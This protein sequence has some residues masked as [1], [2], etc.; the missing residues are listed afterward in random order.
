MHLPWRFPLNIPSA[1]HKIIV[2]L[3][4][5]VATPERLARCLVLHPFVDT[6]DL[7]ASSCVDLKRQMAASGQSNHV[8]LRSLFLAGRLRDDAV[9]KWML[10]RSWVCNNSGSLAEF[11]LDAPA[12]KVPGS[13]EIT[14]MGKETRNAAAAVPLWPELREADKCWTQSL[15]KAEDYLSAVDVT[16]DKINGASEFVAKNVVNVIYD[17]DA[18]TPELPPLLG[19]TD[20]PSARPKVGPGPGKSISWLTARQLLESD[21]AGLSAFLQ[22]ATPVLQEVMMGLT[23]GNGG[24][25]WR[26]E[27]SATMVQL[28]GC[29]A[30]RWFSKLKLR[31][32]RKWLGCRTVK[33][34]VMKRLSTKSSKWHI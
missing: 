1:A 28:H 17:A 20:R 9:I 14:L 23:D 27:F 30:H 18:M 6:D 21:Q 19:F 10:S 34:V 7:L 16:Q 8:Q 32:G 3:A 29:A 26:G 4:G 33:R 12:S 11:I 13:L 2:Q 22:A 25:V 5:E 31:V 24:Q 15:V